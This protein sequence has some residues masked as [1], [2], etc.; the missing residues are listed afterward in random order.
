MDLA[1]E[2]GDT[3]AGVTVETFRSTKSLQRIAERLLEIAG[4]AAGHVPE[5]IRDSIPGNWKGLRSLR[6]LL[7]HAYH[8]VDSA[9]LW[10]AA[11]KSLPRLADE[12]RASLR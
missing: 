11:T 6:V 4:E 12:I 2:L 3:L 10:Q 7:A 1:E 9:Y 5:P 8:R